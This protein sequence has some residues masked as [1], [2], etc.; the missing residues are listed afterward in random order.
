MQP[1]TNN[2]SFDTDKPSVSISLFST[3]YSVV[4]HLRLTAGLNLT[5]S[6]LLQPGGKQI[7]C[8]ISNHID[9]FAFVDAVWSV[10]HQLLTFDQSWPFCYSYQSSL[11]ET[12]RN[13]KSHLQRGFKKNI[14]SWKHMNKTDS[15]QMFV[16]L[17]KQ[18]GTRSR[19]VL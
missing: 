5:P 10:Q 16:I 7:T 9:Q 3:L 17:L 13:K 1:L 8:S 15:K 4:N 2:C 19:S 11:K 14:I 12:K 18:L 6:I